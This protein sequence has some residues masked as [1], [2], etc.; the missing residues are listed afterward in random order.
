MRKLVASCGLAALLACSNAPPGGA[1]NEA[2]TDVAAQNDLVTSLEVE[3]G[4]G[5]VRFVL[6][7]TNTSAQPIRLEFPAAQRYD[8]AVQTPAGSDVW[9]WS[10]DKMFAQ[11]LGEETIPAGGS[12][13]FT[14]TWQPGTH[15]G[16]FVAIGRVTASNRQIEQRASFEIRQP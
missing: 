5:T 7:L 15:S 9:R 11:M 12:R 14:A 16:L 1:P 6:H 13:E 3:V 8:F 4:A 2:R 10:A